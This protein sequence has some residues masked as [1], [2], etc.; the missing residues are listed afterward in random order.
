MR[1][2]GHGRGDRA[3]APPVPLHT[4]ATSFRPPPEPLSSS[5]S[6]SCSAAD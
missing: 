3:T 4:A 2:D 1:P 6:N 5:A